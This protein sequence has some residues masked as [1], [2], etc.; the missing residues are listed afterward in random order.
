MQLRHILAAT[1]ESEA[2]RQAVRSAIA[3]AARALA[4]V[5]ILRVIPEGPTPGRVILRPGRTPDR[6]GDQDRSALAHLRRWLEGGVVS[7]DALEAAQLGVAYGLPGIEICP[8][9]EQVHADLLVVGRKRHSPMAR[10]LLGD[11]ADA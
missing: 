11:T 10:L 4:A 1:D 5:T 6:M 7:P 3:L 2:G 8:V 9:A